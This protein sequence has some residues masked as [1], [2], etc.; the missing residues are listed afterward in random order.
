MSDELPK[1]APRVFPLPGHRTMAQVMAGER[2]AERFERT[3]NHPNSQVG[4]GWNS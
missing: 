4:K 2:A 1:S 3:R